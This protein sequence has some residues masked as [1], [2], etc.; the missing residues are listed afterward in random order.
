MT[1]EAIKAVLES[2]AREIL[3]ANDVADQT[4]KESPLYDRCA[5]KVDAAADAIERLTHPTFFTV[6]GTVYDIDAIAAL[7]KVLSH[8]AVTQ[9]PER[10]MMRM[11]SGLLDRIGD[12]LWPNDWRSSKAARSA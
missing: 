9:Q 12:H 8:A 10:S 6:G 2:F 4:S 3:E 7:Q 1:K 5:S 11:A